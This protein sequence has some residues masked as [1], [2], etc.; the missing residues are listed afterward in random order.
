MSSCHH[1]IMSS[2]IF[3]VAALARLHLEGLCCCVLLLMNR[4]PL[5]SYAWWLFLLPILNMM[6]WTA[7]P[8]S[9]DHEGFPSWWTTSRNPLHLHLLYSSVYPNQY[10]PLIC[11]IKITDWGFIYRPNDVHNPERREYRFAIIIRIG[12]MH[13]LQHWSLPLIVVLSDHFEV[14]I[15]TYRHKFFELSQF[16]DQSKSSIFNI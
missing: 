11:W 3:Y 2:W 14:N 16:T 4:A 8:S 13:R 9:V 5:L 12:I 10:H 15:H 7:Q 6:V 1:V